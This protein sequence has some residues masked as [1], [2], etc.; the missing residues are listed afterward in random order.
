M[1]SRRL[2]ADPLF[3]DDWG[4]RELTREGMRWIEDATMQKVVARRLPD[5]APLMADVRNAFVPWDLPANRRS[6][7]ARPL[8]GAGT[9]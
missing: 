3:T 9:R 1:A 8:D 7:Q 2:K 5:L 6:G 4:P